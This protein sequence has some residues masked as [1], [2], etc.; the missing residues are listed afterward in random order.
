MQPA[1]HAKGHPATLTPSQ[2]ERAAVQLAETHAS[3]LP[4]PLPASPMLDVWTPAL[5]GFLSAG[6]HHAQQAQQAQQQQLGGLSARAQH[7]GVLLAPHPAGGF[8]VENGKAQV[9]G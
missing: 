2:V 3:P 1:V 6:A 4:S 7:P 9:E 8:E 5:R